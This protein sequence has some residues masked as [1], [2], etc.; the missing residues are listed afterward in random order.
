MCQTAVELA[1][2]D[3]RRLD[4]AS[5][6]RKKNALDR[7]ACERSSLIRERTEFLLPTLPNLFEDSDIGD[8]DLWRI[9]TTQLCLNPSF[10]L[11][12]S[13]INNDSCRWRARRYKESQYGNSFK[14]LPKMHFWKF[15]I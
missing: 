6:Q 11:I 9:V 2:F 5:S 1:G 12:I 3:S 15:H 7:L 14:C 8:S 13:V 4:G 10:A